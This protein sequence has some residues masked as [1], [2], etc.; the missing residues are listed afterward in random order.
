MSA[1]LRHHKQ[2]LHI[3]YQSRVGITTS[4]TTMNDNRNSNNNNNNESND[5]DDDDDNHTNSSHCSLSDEPNHH[6]SLSSSSEL[7]VNRN[8]NQSSTTTSM[9]QE[10]PQYSIGTHCKKVTYILYLMYGWMTL[11]FYVFIMISHHFGYVL[12]Y[13]CFF[14]H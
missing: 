14:S 2:Q 7:M 1:A 5:D 6:A 13:H 3:G 12:I 9:Q 10:L 8:N 4:T 11:S